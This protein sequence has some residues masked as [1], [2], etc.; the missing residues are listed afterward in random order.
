MKN[1]L[2]QYCTDYV[3]PGISE[4]F[5][6]PSSKCFTLQEALFCTVGQFCFLNLVNLQKL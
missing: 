1:M 2:L 6:T 4:G 5:E 3:S